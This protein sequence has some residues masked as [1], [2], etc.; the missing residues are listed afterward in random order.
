MI[1]LAAVAL[2]AVFIG[3]RLPA[4]FLPPGRSR[5][6]LRSHTITGCG[7]VAANRMQQLQR[8]TDALL[9]NARSSKR[10]RR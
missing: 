10:C 6:S 4:G 3:N 7:V 9:S 8:V 1:G 5:L 2:L